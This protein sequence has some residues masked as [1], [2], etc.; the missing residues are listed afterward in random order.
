MGGL[1]TGQGERRS[2]GSGSAE[3]RVHRGS[4]RCRGVSGR[5]DRRAARAALS[6]AG[7]TSLLDREAWQ[8][9]EAPAGDSGDSGSGGAGGGEDRDRADLRGEL[10]AV[11]ERV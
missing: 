6:A 8:T 10:P 2:A 11:L 5:A 9:R 7:G 4:D 1:E 3:F